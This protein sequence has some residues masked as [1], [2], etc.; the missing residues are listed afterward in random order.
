MRKSH[1]SVAV[2]IQTMV[3]SEVAGVAFTV[4]PVTRDKNHMIIE[5][6]W[7]LGELLVGG[8]VTPD[9]YI[10]DKR[11]G[12]LL[13]VNIHTQEQGL[14]RTPKGNALKKIPT[15]QQEQ[16]KLDSAQIR[17]LADL[18]K[19]I[20]THYGF[21]CDIEWGMISGEFYIL[22]SRPITTLG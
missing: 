13:E 9:S 10:V 7:G 1:V 12:T 6:C 16:Q 15:K 20:E 22:Q 4:H 21:P 14:F 5:A 3:Q 2:V 19:T 11:D 8:S 17:Q 18:C